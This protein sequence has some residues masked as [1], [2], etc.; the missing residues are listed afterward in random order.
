MSSVI[1]RGSAS[2]NRSYLNAN[3]PELRKRQ[4]CGLLI[5]GIFVVLVLTAVALTIVHISEVPSASIDRPT[6]PPLNVAP[7]R[8]PTPSAPVLARTATPTNTP[9]TTGFQ[10]CNGYESLCDVPANQVLYATVHNAVSSIED[11]VT[12]V[13]NHELQL[14]KALQSGWRGLNFDIGK[15]SDFT[16]QPVRLVHGLCAI[17]SRDPIEVFTNIQT[18]LDSNPNEVLLMPIQIDNS[19]DGG[20]VSYA[21]IYAILEQV[22]D[23]TSLLYQ[24]PGVGTPWPTLRE[25]IAANT[26]ILLFFYDGATLC[27]D[28][29]DGCPA[30]F[31][32]W[33]SYAA[34]T[35]FEFLTADE[36]LVFTNACVITRGAS[37]TR[38][39]FGINYFT[40]IPSA[41]TAQEINQYA[42]VKTH[43]ETCAALNEMSPSLI[44][45]DYWNVG[46]VSD[47]VSD[48]DALLS[49]NATQR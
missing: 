18:F 27:V 9:T 30:G 35:A 10:A 28:S 16:E 42:L 43:V 14:E 31:H 44:L 25:L 33:F 41:S 46:N 4:Q 3:S 36:L 2:V 8:P 11:G 49:G 47:V 29:A 15:C 39:F 1:S 23:F 48:Y 6:A 20:S 19:L 37:G 13:P 24:H 40:T 17:G 5:A 22:P 12:I 21:E 26:R 7:V 45:V 34:E 32:D 38:D